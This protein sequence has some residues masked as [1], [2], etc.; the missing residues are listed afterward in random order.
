MAYQKKVSEVQS[1]RD[2]LR[3]E[4]NKYREEAEEKFLE[5]EIYKEERENGGDCV[6]IIN[7]ETTTQVTEPQTIEF[8]SF[9]QLQDSSVLGVD[10]SQFDEK[11][12]KRLLQDFAKF[13]S[14]NYTSNKNDLIFGYPR[15]YFTD[16]QLQQFVNVVDNYKAQQK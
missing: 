12:Q 2:K 1:E 10:F 7:E 5:F 6:R 9:E 8:K 16:K 13:F 11:T 15:T 14:C 3:N 4:F